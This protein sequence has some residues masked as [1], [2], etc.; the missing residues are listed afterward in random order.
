MMDRFDELDALRGLPKYTVTHSQW[1][2]A[3]FSRM[4]KLPEEERARFNLS[5]HRLAIHTAAPCPRM[6]KEEREAA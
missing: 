5:A 2:P 6:V 4:L 3:I 1:V